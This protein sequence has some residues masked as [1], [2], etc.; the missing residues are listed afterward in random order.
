MKDVLFEFQEKALKEMRQA[1]TLA[2]M[3]YQKTQKPQV[4]ALSAPTGSG[5]TNILI[6]FIENTL[7]GDEIKPAEPNSVFIWLS[8][9]PELNNQTRLKFEEKGDRLSPGSLVTIESTY[10][11][12]M[13]SPGHIYFINTQKLGRDKLLTK[14]SDSRQY[15]IWETIQNTVNRNPRTY[16]IIDEAH[17]GTKNDR[18]AREAQSIMQKFIVGSPEDGISPMPLIIGISATPQRFLKLVSATPSTIFRVPVA[19]EDVRESGLLKDRIFI[20]FPDSNQ[21]PDMAM[22]QAAA[23]DWKEKCDHWEWYSNYNEGTLVEPVLVIQV[24]DGT[25]NSVTATDLGAC[26]KTIEERIGIRFKS[27]DVAHTFNDYGD[28]KADG[29]D[30]Y[31]IEPSS[32]EERKSIKVVFFKM[33]L[34]T[35]W[36]CPRAETMM[37]FRRATDSTYIAQLLG[38]MIRTPLARRIP[39]DEVLNDVKLF[40]PHFD[41]HTVNDVVAALKETDGPDIPSEITTMKKTTILTANPI[42]SIHSPSSQNIQEKDD[43]ESQK[44]NSSSF[45]FHG[46]AVNVTNQPVTNHIEPKTSF[47]SEDGQSNPANSDGTV[48]EPEKPYCGSSSKLDDDLTIPPVITSDVSS[49]S[50]VKPIIPTFDRLQVI[51]AINISA[52][53]TY[54]VSKTKKKKAS[55]SL[56]DLVNLLVL[57]GINTDAKDDAVDS[58]VDLI[59]ASIQR[60]KEEGIFAD[61]SK[62]A[63]QFKLKTLKVDSAWNSE[64]LSSL[65][66][67]MLTTTLDID[68]KYEIAN[69]LLGTRSVGQTFLKKYGD[70]DDLDSSKIEVIVFT[71][72]SECMSK[73][74]YQCD[75]MFNE[76]YDRSRISVSK[77]SD[78]IRNRYNDIGALSATIKRGILNLPYD[79]DFPMYTKGEI[80]NDHLYA[81]NNGQ[82]RIDLNSWEHGLIKEE[83]SQPDFVCWLRFVERKSWSILIPYEMNHEKRAAYPDMLIVRKHGFD[84]FLFDILEPHD[85]TRRDNLG[86]AKG[87][88]K[89]AEENLSTEIGHLQLIRYEKGDDG[90]NHFLRL[91]LTKR[92]TR[93][94]VL[95]ANSNDE[96]DSIFAS[97]GFYI[98]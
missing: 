71:D 15:S 78:N 83:E 20:K 48:Q 94:K 88:A 4:I 32:I 29:I 34:S 91:D 24:L 42:I 62:K 22:L 49:T 11:S 28:L 93:E 77:A 5:K 33:N 23:D 76:L 1:D 79:I 70:L 9:S 14:I 60:M 68:K 66:D 35:G 51:K 72:N 73:Y 36:D 85:P 17:K 81:D 21:M 30:I 82:V 54:S 12:E 43:S 27:G 59:H 19:A 65:S 47:V 84:D 58:L 3:G 40:L 18:E 87:F 46:P 37:S 67:S 2:V 7:F 41:E 55:K 16:L 39:S 86:K 61:L 26:L 96:I 74:E 92:E 75:R 63:T 45:G 57:N 25:N 38:R 31:Y 8:D 89:Y 53:S 95:K 50:E 90:H 10:D 56:F 80:F 6:S 13:L 52:L 64:I 69:A 97:N 44:G 98:Q